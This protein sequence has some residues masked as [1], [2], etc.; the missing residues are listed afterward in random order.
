M[1]TIKDEDGRPLEEWK[2]GPLPNDELPRMVERFAQLLREQQELAESMKELTAEARS[3]SFDPAAMK[4]AAKLR[5][6]A[7]GKLKFEEGMKTLLDY[8]EAAGDPLEI[9][10]R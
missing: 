4:R 6:N 2:G 1:A 3:K 9:G 10:A 5:I 8:M 7:A